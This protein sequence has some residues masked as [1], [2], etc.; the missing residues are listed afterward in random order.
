MKKK[1]IMFIIGLGMLMNAGALAQ[2]GIF[3]CVSC[4][5]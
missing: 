3:N 1:K 2:T 5:K 4:Y